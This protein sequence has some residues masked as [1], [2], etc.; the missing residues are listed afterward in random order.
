V[1]KCV[2]ISC[3]DYYTTR[4]KQVLRIFEEKGYKTTYLISDFNHFSKSKVAAEYSDCMQIS[5]P[6]YKKNLSPARLYSHHV[7]SKGVYRQLCKIK[8]EVIYCMIPPNSL[9]RDVVKYKQRIGAY[10]IFDCYDM[11]PESFP[12]EKYGKLLAFP[13][14]KWRKLRDDYVESADKMIVVSEA[15]KIGWNKLHPN[16]EVAVVPPYIEAGKLPESKEF[17]PGEIS[18]CYLGMINHIT[19][20]E[21]GVRFLGELQKK[22]HVTLHLIGEG[23]NKDAF[24]SSLEQAG[25]TVVQHGVVFDMD[26][27][28][29]IFSQCDMGLNIPRPEIKSTMPLK[30]VEYMRAGLPFVNAGL[31]DVC[32]IVHSEQIG[33]NVDEQSVNET[34]ARIFAMD[35]A[36]MNKMRGNCAAYYGRQS[37]THDFDKILLAC[38]NENESLT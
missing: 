21:L 23:Q 24:V 2:V 17:H 9:V 8:P 12:Y 35:E 11:W 13:F 18:F 1:K 32:T 28:N 6:A 10:V 3:F 14:N 4:T 27:K 30:G 16:M 25:V 7:F 33:I 15:G 26:K 19:D 31:G 20:T 5:V 22:W 37:V 34:V 38:D 29:E 36:T